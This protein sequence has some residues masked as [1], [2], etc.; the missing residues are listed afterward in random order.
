MAKFYSTI[1]NKLPPHIRADHFKPYVYIQD[2]STGEPMK[3]ADDRPMTR[4][5]DNTDAPLTTKE[6]QKWVTPKPLYT[7]LADHDK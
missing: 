7:E 1:I 6:I 4:P 3:A 5:W 2:Y